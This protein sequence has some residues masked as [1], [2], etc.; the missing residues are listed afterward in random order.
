MQ[1]FREIHSIIIQTAKCITH[2]ARMYSSGMDSQSRDSKRSL[3]FGK[4]SK[5]TANFISGNWAIKT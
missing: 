3:M 2:Y 5:M 1:L 4:V